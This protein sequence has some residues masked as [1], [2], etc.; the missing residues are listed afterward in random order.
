LVFCVPVLKRAW[1][2]F[3]KKPPKITRSWLLPGLQHFGNARGI[4]GSLDF[5][6]GQVE[7]NVDATW[8]L[9]QQKLEAFFH[10][11]EE[12]SGD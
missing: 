4:L 5:L 7:T 6:N 2:R 3:S 9:V 8:D 1:G 11:P 10:P 12:D